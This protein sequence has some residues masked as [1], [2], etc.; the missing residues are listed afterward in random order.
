[1]S[2]PSPGTSTRFRLARIAGLILGSLLFLHAC[3]RS[4]SALLGDVRVEVA[5]A[6][7]FGAAALVAAWFEI[8]L[9]ALEDADPPWDDAEEADIPVPGNSP[10]RAGRSA[11]PA[12]GGG[13]RAGRIGIGARSAPMAQLQDDPPDPG[14]LGDHDETEQITRTERGELVIESGARTV[15][16]KMSRS[17]DLVLH[18][19]SYGA[20]R[21]EWKW[22]FTPDAFPAIRGVLGDG[23]GDL[24]DLLEDT[25]P[26]LEATARHDPGA[27]L[28][29]HDIPATYQ[30]KGVSATQDTRKLPA[31][32]PEHPPQPPRAS[33]SH[34]EPP[35]AEPS[36]GTARAAVGA[37]ERARNE[38]RRETPAATYSRESLA[39][40]KSRQRGADSAPPSR[41]ADADRRAH[42]DKP[43]PAGQPN[44]SSDGYG[45]PTQSRR[46]RDEPEPG[47][48][49]DRLPRTDA[50]DPRPTPGRPDLP[51]RRHS[52]DERVTRHAPG[53]PR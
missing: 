41:R 21:L 3:E 11:A 49:G 47:R 27:W 39:N 29:A 20:A 51:R 15:R 25:L 28:R 43:G 35:R 38:P 31:L 23:P 33:R 10:G 34:R 6:A 24:L 40:E 30:E 52:D 19:R 1:M 7:A 16:A 4:E 5:F 37:D 46:H 12:Y 17:G 2:A 13:E 44:R 32:P 50:A 48:R 22:T 9:R 53:R 42:G 26:W 14:E 18:G 8:K 36:A 45:S